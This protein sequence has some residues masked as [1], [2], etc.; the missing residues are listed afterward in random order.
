MFWF[1]NL[2]LMTS[3]S[4]LLLITVINLQETLLSLR[5]NQNLMFNVATIKE[6]LSAL[7]IIYFI[8]LDLIHLN[9]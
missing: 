8:K 1:L 2:N 3:Q 9:S 4:N 5:N 6:Q 7:A